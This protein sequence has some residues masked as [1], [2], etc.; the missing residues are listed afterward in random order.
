M[1]ELYGLDDEMP[2]E[3][4]SEGDEPVDEELVDEPEDD[5]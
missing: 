1:G 5:D 2:E 4:E 3:L